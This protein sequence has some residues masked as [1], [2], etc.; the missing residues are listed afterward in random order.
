MSFTN[1]SDTK[2]NHLRYNNRQRKFETFSDYHR[3]KLLKEKPK[4][5]TLLEDELSKFNSRSTYIATFQQYV[6]KRNEIDQ[7]LREFYGKII[8]RIRKWVRYKKTQ[9]SEDKLV[10]NV[11][12]KFGA[13]AVLSIGDWDCM[14]QYRGIHP[15][16]TSGVKRKL[17]KHFKVFKVPEA[18]TTMTCYKCSQRHMEKHSYRNDAKGKPIYP[19]GI[20]HCQNE[21]CGVF[22]ERDYNAALNI[23]RN[24]LYY[25]QNG[26]WMKQFQYEN[27]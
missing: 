10:N 20:R 27:D 6:D 5:I 26:E 11:K 7:E 8:Y 4:R 19:H 17:C 18:Y 21:S 22:M 25:I 12:E 2:Q 23:R 14:Y 16:P 15:S 1:D 13:N 24:M 3:K 9:Q